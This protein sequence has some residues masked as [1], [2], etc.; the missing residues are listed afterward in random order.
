MISLYD[1][2]KSIATSV[3]ATLY[4]SFWSSMLVAFFSMFVYMYCHCTQQNEKSYKS[5]VAD[6]ID[7][8]KHSV[9]FRKIFCCNFLFAMILFRTLLNR[10]LWGNPLSD[11]M[12]GWWIWKTSS[13]GTVKLTT[14]CFENMALMFPFVIAFLWAE[15]ERILKR[16][17]F[18]KVILISAKL[19]FFFSL[20]IEFLQLFL[21]VGTFQF[22]DIFYNTTGGILGGIVYWIV[23]RIKN[24][25]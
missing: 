18:Q 8:F 17:T 15:E 4:Y 22:S 6:W 19:S 20:T 2:I 14:E 1:I 10:D 25:C 13:D 16:V 3:L 12:G 5:A 7:Q 23:C 11:V 9:R 21:R 24:K